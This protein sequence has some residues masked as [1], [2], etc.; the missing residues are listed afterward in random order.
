MAQMGA[1]RKW[2]TN[3]RKWSVLVVVVVL[4]AVITVLA[5][6]R[7]LEAKIARS[8]KPSAIG[9]TLPRAQTPKANFNFTYHSLNGA[10]H[11]LSELKGKVA[12]LN[13][14]DTWCIRCVAEMPTIQQ[15]YNTL[16]KDPSIAF[17]MTS[18]LDTP[19]RMRLYAKYGHYNLSF[20]TVND[21]DIPSAI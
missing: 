6:F 15:L 17:V 16:E 12:F 19:A 13:F 11:D 21:S 14:W 20:Y 7:L 4:L 3:L 10:P 1:T 9:Q 8:F 5:V 18:R 2:A